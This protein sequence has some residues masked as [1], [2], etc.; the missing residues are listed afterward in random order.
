VVPFQISIWIARFFSRPLLYFIS[1]SFNFF[2][3]FIFF[4][5]IFTARESTAKT[6]TS[7]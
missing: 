3:F 4:I 7:G 1:L 2:I 5:F 6:R